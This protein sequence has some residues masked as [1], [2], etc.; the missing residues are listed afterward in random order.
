MAALYV[1]MTMLQPRVYTPDV[2]LH[3]YYP[4]RWGVWT[5]PR[6]FQNRVVLVCLY[7]YTFRP[8]CTFIIT[9]CM[10]STWHYKCDIQCI[11]DLMVIEHEH[12]NMH[13]LMIP[14]TLPIQNLL[15]PFVLFDSILSRACVF[16]VFY[17]HVT[18]TDLQALF[19]LLYLL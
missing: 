16:M 9:L 7:T 3:S 4:T 18:Y 10:I 14:N 2:P 17:S 12:N 1:C 13:S 6:H 11:T 19:M 5:Q 15:V 8:I